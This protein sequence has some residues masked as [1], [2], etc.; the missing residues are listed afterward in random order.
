MWYILSLFLMFFSGG[1]TKCGYCSTAWYA[2]T[3]PDH[4]TPCLTGVSVIQSAIC[5]YGCVQAFC[6]VLTYENGELVNVIVRVA[7]LSV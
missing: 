6:S 5:K 4:N 7:S 3:A 1:S 2:A